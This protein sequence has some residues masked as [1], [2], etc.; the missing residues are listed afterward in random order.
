MVL[1]DRATGAVA[2]RVAHPVIGKT[3]QRPFFDGP[4]I[5]LGAPPRA[6]VAVYGTS[7]QGR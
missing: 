4:F 3:L 1:L 5:V 7:A 2:E 6:D